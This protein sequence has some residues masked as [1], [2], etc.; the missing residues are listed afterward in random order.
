MIPTAP[1]PLP[2]FEHVNIYWDR[3]HEMHAAKILPGEYY[4]TTGKEMIATVLGSCV[5]ACI[6]DP[7]VN[8]GGMNH[9]MLPLNS[10]Q[11]LD[12]DVI[13]A[14]TRYGNYAM[15]HLINDVIKYGGK[16]ENLEVKIFGGG[17]VIQQMTTV[18]VGE[19]NIQFIKDYLLMEGIS[20]KSQNV[21]DVFP[22]KILYSPETGVVKMKRLRTL[23]NDTLMR[24]EEKYLHAI[25][26]QPVT[27]DVELF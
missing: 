15:E 16:K 17:R 19:K 21:G 2:G 1:I 8:V 5:S 6:R 10:N 9:F 3:K 12:L 26:Q 18:N 4:V 7:I 23:H 14:A 20:I 24:R 11:S 25:N 27:S 22:R 13:G